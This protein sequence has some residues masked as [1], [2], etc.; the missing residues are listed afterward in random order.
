MSDE[1]N[2]NGFWCNLPRSKL[3]AIQSDSFG[4]PYFKKVIMYSE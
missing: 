4:L 2:E 3:P 1:N